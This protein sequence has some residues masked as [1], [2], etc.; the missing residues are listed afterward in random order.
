MA[1]GISEVDNSSQAL[2]SSTGHIN[3]HAVFEYDTVHS[4]ECFSDLGDMVQVDDIC[5][6]GSIEAAPDEF[7][8]EVI[9]V[10]VRHQFLL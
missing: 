8:L 5:S 3:L 9:Q 10:S 4:L 6:A 1:G 7:F 2:G